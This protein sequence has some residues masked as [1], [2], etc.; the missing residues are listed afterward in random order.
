[1]T[2]ARA[3]TYG[4]ARLIAGEIDAFEWVRRDALHTANVLRALIAVD[5]FVQAIDRRNAVAHSV[6]F[7]DIAILGRSTVGKIRAS[8]CE[9]IP[10]YLVDAGAR[11]AEI[12]GAFTL[13]RSITTDAL[14]HSVAILIDTADEVQGFIRIVGHACIA[15]VFRAGIVVLGNVGIEVFDGG[16]AGAV[17]YDA[18]AIARR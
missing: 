3:V 1:L 8:G 5:G 7:D 12:V 17:T 18:F 9:V 2:C 14:A 15:Y 11:F 13:I 6:A 10:A 16:S 4:P